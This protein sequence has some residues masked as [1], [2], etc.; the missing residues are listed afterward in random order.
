[1][2]VP[3]SDL[4][5]PK[6]IIIIIIIISNSGVKNKLLGREA[7]IVNTNNRFMHYTVYCYPATDKQWW[8]TRTIL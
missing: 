7:S 3:H 8:M 1:M 4:S 2:F 6:L 5:F